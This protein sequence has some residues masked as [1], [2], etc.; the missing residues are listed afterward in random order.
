ML[1]IPKN[2]ATEG[3]PFSLERNSGEN[4]SLKHPLVSV[5]PLDQSVGMAAVD[6][7]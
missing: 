5:Q 4:L 6:P 3:Q 1:L 7:L 2:S